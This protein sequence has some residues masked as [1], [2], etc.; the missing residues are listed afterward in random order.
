MIM[1]RQH[2]AL[3]LQ[4]NANVAENNTIHLFQNSIFSKMEQVESDT[5]ENSGGRDLTR[6]STRI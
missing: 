4:K 5:G 6:I 1:S 2:T 3:H